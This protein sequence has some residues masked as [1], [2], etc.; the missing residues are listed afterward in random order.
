M[1][2][3]PAEAGFSMPAEWAPH[4]RT[5]IAWPSRADLWGAKLHAAQLA[6]AAVAK[7]IAAFEPVTM[8]ANA[9]DI[10]AVRAAC[11]PGVTPLALPIDDSWLRDSGPSFLT[12][13]Q[14]A[15]AAAD[16]GFNAWGE[17]FPPWDK[18]AAVAG[19]ILNIWASTPS[20]PISSWKA[21]PSMWMATA[22]CS[23]RN[24]AC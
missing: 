21:A 16:W 12:N 14:G 8:V 22:A 3:T 6:Y 23:P 17:K 1:P 13:A 4:S 9:A 2:Q 7:A 19:R 20:K 10:D 5:W 11:G 18:D 24:N 15:M